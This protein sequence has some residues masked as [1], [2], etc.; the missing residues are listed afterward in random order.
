M[1]L[2]TTSFYFLCLALSS[3]RDIIDK[4]VANHCHLTF[5]WHSRLKFILR[6]IGLTRRCVKV[7]FTLWPNYSDQN[8]ILL[9]STNVMFLWLDLDNKLVR[10]FSLPSCNTKNAI[11]AWN[12]MPNQLLQVR[13]SQKGSK[14]LPKFTSDDL[15]IKWLE[16]RCLAVVHFWH[17]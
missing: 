9:L 8:S 16:D 14:S 2:W 12:E 7:F 10:N 17:L 5:V 6:L 4:N 11:A 15:K 13:F 1:P 3:E